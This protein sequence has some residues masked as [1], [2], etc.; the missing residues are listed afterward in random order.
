MFILPVAL[1]VGA[2][3]LLIRGRRRIVLI[4]AVGAPILSVLA[5]IAQF[6]PGGVESCTSSTSGPDVCQSLPAVTAWEGP[7]PYSIAIGLIVL[8]LA[9][10]V[11]V[12]TGKWWPAAVSAVL[13]A[14]PQVISFGGF[15]DWAPAL[16][17]TVAVAF[18]AAG[19]LPLQEPASASATRP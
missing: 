19:P 5:F 18:A 14:I 1:V 13:Q 3:G 4:V 12:R 2:L 6:V 7:L 11:S 15:L 9:P 10:L 17:V 16:A 8:S